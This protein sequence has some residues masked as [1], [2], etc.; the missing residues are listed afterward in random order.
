MAAL[1]QLTDEFRAIENMIAENEGEV[2]EAEI[3]AMDDIKDDFKKKA[4]SVAKMIQNFKGEQSAIKA[5]AQRLSKRASSLGNK[6]DWLKSYVK[7]HMIAM[8]FDKIKGEILSLTLRNVKASVEITDENLIPDKL[9]EKVVA[10]K[11]D[12][13]GC[14]EAYKAGEF[15]PGITV[16]DGNKSL[17]IR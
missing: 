1:Y 2:S 10:F 15:I 5:E 13:A 6:I 8:G 14:L 9:K 17:T 11:V 4:E 7:N 3:I 16:H 12:K